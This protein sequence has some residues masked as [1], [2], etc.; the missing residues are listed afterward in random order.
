MKDRKHICRLFFQIV[1][2]IFVYLTSGTD[3]F[4]Q[5]R[6]ITGQVFESDDM[7]PLMGAIVKI[8]GTTLAVITDNDGLFSL[9]T[10][11]NSILLISFLGYIPKEVTVSNSSKLKILLESDNF[12]LNEMV[13]IGYGTV[14]KKDIT[15]AIGIVDTKE[16][17]RTAN[18]SISGALQGRVAGL[19]VKGTAMPGDASKIFIRGISS[20]YSNTDPLFVI[21]GLPTEDSRDINPQDI[22]S[23]QVL[24]DASAASIYGSRAANGVIIITTKRGDKKKTKFE[25][26]SNT[27]YQ[28]EVKRYDLMDGKEWYAFQKTI[29]A[30]SGATMQNY[31]DS[32]IN[33]NWQDLVYQKGLVQNY[34]FSASGGGEN[35]NFMISGDYFGQNGVVIGPKFDRY[36]LRA[37][38]GLKTKRL[39]IEESLLLSHTI[40][41]DPVT[42]A[43]NSVVRIPPLL[44][45]LDSLGQPTLGYYQGIKYNQG[46]NPMSHI[47]NESR[48]NSSFHA[49]GSLNLEYTIFDF[50]KY[51]LNLGYEARSQEYETKRTKEIWYP[52]Q[53]PKSGYT[54]ERNMKTMSLVEN[55]LNFDK[56]FGKHSINALVGYTEQRDNYSYL[57]GEVEGIK[58][59]M[60]GNYQWGL[61]FGNTETLVAYQGYSPSAL[62]SFLGR[63]IYSYDDRY[64]F[65]G[66]IRRDGSSKFSKNNR[67]GNFPSASAAWRISNEEF[68]KKY[69]KII[70]DMKIRVSYGKLGNQ[71]IGDFKY[72]TYT[73][74]FQP[75]QFGQNISWGTTQLDIIDPNIQWETKESSNIGIDI[76]L[77][78]NKVTVSAEYFNNKSDKLLA[79]VR[80]PSSTG[81]WDLTPWINAGSVENRGLE[82]NVAYK[83]Y[84]K[85]FKYDISFITTFLKNKV[86]SLGGT[87]QYIQDNHTRTAVGR[88]LGEF[89]LIKTDGI[90]TANDEN[91]INSIKTYNV[92]PNRKP[93]VGDIKYIDI[94]GDSIINAE[95]RQ[96]VGNPWPKAE[97]SVNFTCSFKNFDMSMYWYSLLG[98][99]VYNNM[100]LSLYTPTYM[101]NMVSGADWYSEK[102]PNGKIFKPYL[103]ESPYG[104]CDFFLEDGSF[105]RLKS[106]QLGYNMP[107]SI[108]KS[109]GIDKFRVFIGGENLITFS[110]YSGLDPD[111]QGNVPF[112]VGVDNNKYPAVRTFSLGAQFGF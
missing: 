11:E 110:K 103:D 99:K 36:S 95:D 56:T 42:S 72:T 1:L 2:F 40:T 23:I 65:T 50:L 8:K 85:D 73:N 21:D 64:F 101:G 79:K 17:K 74:E 91:Y 60:S 104:D 86:V 82:L 19:S 28:K 4:A 44:P 25:F 83:N 12:M 100:N 97:F 81:S 76:S 15:G 51:K 75:Y 62:R 63:A 10:S 46:E 52:N 70:N 14:K 22:E 67:Y 27:G 108:T 9:K 66:S 69:L 38:G 37:N 89:Y 33:T 112:T 58:S 109:I 5:Q 20:I 41:T 48:Q 3:A 29:H 39:R 80:V 93:K 53:D 26:S 68:F 90:V 16:M 98:R 92:S 84:S 61:G 7:K 71:A 111:F 106:L 94:N 45:E 49:L 35:S 54:N 78:G 24:K 59:D 102:N 31:P 47:K 43:H 30:N 105:L 18:T 87:N 107:E 96:Y 13:T 77:M 32:T 57:R 6:D 34:N 88:S 55:T